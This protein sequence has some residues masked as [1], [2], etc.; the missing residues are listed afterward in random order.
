MNVNGAG[1]S[2]F[3][4]PVQSRPVQRMSTGGVN[5]REQADNDMA[6]KMLPMQA[7]EAA[8]RAATEA[9]GMFVDTYA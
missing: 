6:R 3:M 5:A 8:G 9:K 2:T 4:Q 7:A 1:G